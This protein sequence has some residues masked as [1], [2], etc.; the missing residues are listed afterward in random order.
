MQ[1]VAI[2]V[3]VHASNFLDSIQY[4]EHVAK[5]Y[6][7]VTGTPKFAI[8]YPRHLLSQAR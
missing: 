5:F 6:H 3:K 1:V 2:Q 4:C 8:N 7:V